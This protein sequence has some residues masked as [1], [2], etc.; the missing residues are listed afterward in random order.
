MKHKNI[1]TLKVMAETTFKLIHA[2]LSLHLET[3]SHWQTNRPFY[4]PILKLT[5]QLNLNG[6]FSESNEPSRSIVLQTLNYLR[7]CTFEF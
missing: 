7:I 5:K 3:K 4:I 1:I 6:Y 2:L